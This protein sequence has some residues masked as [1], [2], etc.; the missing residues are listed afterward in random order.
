MVPRLPGR[1]ADSKTESKEPRTPTNVPTAQACLIAARNAIAAARNL[2]EAGQ[3]EAA[4]FYALW[5]NGRAREVSPSRLYFTDREGTRVR[6]LP[7]QMAGDSA[8]RVV[9]W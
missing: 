8:R 3:L 9:V 2:T 4:F 5:A 7:G 1:H 6:R